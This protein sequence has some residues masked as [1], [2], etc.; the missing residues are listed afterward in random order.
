M[1]KQ[2]VLYADDL[3]TS[4]VKVWTG[5]SAVTNNYRGLKAIDCENFDTSD[6][7]FFG[8]HGKLIM[9][10]K[11]GNDL[12]VTAWITNDEVLPSYVDIQNCRDE[13]ELRSAKLSGSFSASWSQ[14]FSYDQK[15]GF[16]QVLSDDVELGSKCFSLNSNKRLVLSDCENA[17]SFGRRIV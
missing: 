11:W 3:C 13:V 4:V 8:D 7:S 1:G 9:Q 16:I 17:V 10:S 12:C 15:T 14:Q 5:G 6:F 2:N